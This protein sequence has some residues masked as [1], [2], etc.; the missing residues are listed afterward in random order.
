MLGRIL[1]VAT[2]ELGPAVWVPAM[3]SGAE[4]AVADRMSMVL[5]SVSLK[6]DDLAVPCDFPSA[7][8]C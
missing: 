6:A 8:N 7:V 1:S 4:L 5:L 3:A 2:V